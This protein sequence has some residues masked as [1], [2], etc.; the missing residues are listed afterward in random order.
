[1]LIQSR[2]HPSNPRAQQAARIPAEIVEVTL[3]N[4]QITTKFDDRLLGLV[5]TWSYSHALLHAAVGRSLDLDV[6]IGRISLVMDLRAEKPVPVICGP[7]RYESDVVPLC[8]EGDASLQK[9]VSLAFS[10]SQY[11]YIIGPIFSLYQ[12]SFEDSILE[13][14]E[15][16]LEALVAD[17]RVKSDELREVKEHIF[18]NGTMHLEQRSGDAPL[19]EADLSIKLF[20]SRRSAAHNVVTAP[21]SYMATSEAF[22]D[23][24]AKLLQRTGLTNDEQDK[25]SLLSYDVDR[26]PEWYFDRRTAKWDTCNGEVPADLQHPFSE[27]PTFFGESPG[28]MMKFVSKLGLQVSKL[29][30]SRSTT[31]DAIVSV[32]L[33]TDVD[34]DLSYMLDIM[35]HMKSEMDLGYVF[36][37]GIVQVEEPWRSPL[38]AW[39]PYQR[40]RFVVVA[41]GFI[42][43]YQSRVYQD[44][45]G[46]ICTPG[47]DSLSSNCACVGKNMNAIFTIDMQKDIKIMKKRDGC[48]QLLVNGYNRQF[49]FCAV[50]ASKWK[51]KLQKRFTDAGI[52]KCLHRH[53]LCTDQRLQSELDEQFSAFRRAV[54]VQFT[55]LQDFSSD[56][57]GA[58]NT[59]RWPSG[60]PPYVENA[61]TWQRSVRAIRDSTTAQKCEELCVRA[62]PICAGYEFTSHEETRCQLRFQGSYSKA[63][64]DGER[65]WNVQTVGVGFAGKLYK[66]I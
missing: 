41:C 10:S 2:H 22:A 65:I 46:K 32:G 3:S 15:G 18:L 20:A 43:G 45:S 25:D 36:A 30:L 31:S 60:W 4:L 1:V 12:T 29:D 8:G 51:D 50:D 48:L 49:S 40:P 21:R 17:I 13:A 44:C 16:A 57:G 24:A 7:I 54:D 55:R 5:D 27:Q 9:D 42:V 19:G 38:F 28:V 59:G 35:T 53:G 61:F 62:G 63:R 47:R 39:R 58:E 66:H 14:V 6:A 37:S 33:E 23:G 52:L 64:L 34:L 56:C 11:W 26:T